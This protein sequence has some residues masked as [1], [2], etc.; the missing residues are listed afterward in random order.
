MSALPG[1]LVSTERSSRC[2]HTG[3]RT[4]SARPGPDTGTGGP[5][6]NYTTE[7]QP[8]IKVPVIGGWRYLGSISSQSSSA[9]PSHYLR[10]HHHHH[11][12]SLHLQPHSPQRRHN[13]WAADTMSVR[14]WRS[15]LKQTD[16]K[17][18]YYNTQI[19][20]LSLDFNC[21]NVTKQIFIF[22]LTKIHIFNILSQ[23]I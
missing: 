17:Y 8:S 1:L 3:S 13:Y 5:E 19:I 16:N 12:H 2:V 15:G 18:V 22:Y 14:C 11:H 10:H 20:K 21:Q 6:E 9:T 23:L 7:T 4:G